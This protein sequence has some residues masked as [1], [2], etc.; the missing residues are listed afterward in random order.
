MNRFLLTLLALLTGL[1]TP[2]ASAQAAVRAKGEAEISAVMAASVVAQRSGHVAVRS[3]VLAR[4]ER[5]ALASKVAVQPMPVI[6]A[7]SIHIG[8]DRARE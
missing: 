8:I 4:V 3:T 5:V 7:P 1:V 2:V 6:A